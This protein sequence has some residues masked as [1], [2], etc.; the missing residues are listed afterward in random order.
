M[1]AII[2]GKVFNGTNFLENKAVI[3]KDKKIVDIVSQEEIF[4]QYSDIKTIDAKGGYVTPGFIDLQLNGC[5]GVLVNDSITRETFEVMSKTNLKYGCTLCTPTL[6]T[7]TDENIRKGL[8]LIDSMEDKEDIGVIGLH[9]EGPFISV[10]KKGIHNPKF[11]RP[12][13]KEILERIVKT[14]KKGVSIITVAPEN[15]SGEYIGILANSGIKVALGHTNATYKEIQEKKIFGITLA[16]HL[17][18]GMSS[19]THREPGAAGA[20]MNLD[21]SAGIVVDGF[22]CDYASVQIAKKL[23]GD[24]LYLVTDAVAPVGTDMEYFYFEGNKVYHKDGK[25]FGE[26]GTLGG[27]ALTMIAGVQNLVNHVKLS[28][29]EAVKMATIIPAKAISIDDRYG[30]IQPGYF[31]DIV[32]MDKELNLTQV[33]TKGKIV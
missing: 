5:G 6:I 30:K 17:Y 12:M 26:D 1:F 14:G 2:N 20:T 24:R 22:H 27:S 25:C 16:T 8:D 29:E 9:I 4:K 18:N 15:I 23:M 31:A 3:I 11:I 21:I 32:I 13:D 28:V 19:F 33:I 10:E 7:T